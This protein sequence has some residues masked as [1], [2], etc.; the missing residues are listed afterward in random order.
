MEL[1][2]TSDEEALKFLASHKRC[3]TTG[4]LAPCTCGW[5]GTDWWQHR[6]TVFGAWLEGQRRALRARLLVEEGVQRP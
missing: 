6:H 1:H 4:P 3:A 2:I 5:A